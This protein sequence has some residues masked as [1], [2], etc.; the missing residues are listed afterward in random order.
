MTALSARE[1]LINLAKNEYDITY[2]L[3]FKL[4]DDTPHSI[5]VVGNQKV[6]VY[7][8]IPAGEVILRTIAVRANEQVNE[9]QSTF[10]FEKAAE[11]FDEFPDAFENFEAAYASLSSIPASAMSN[12]KLVLRYASIQ[13]EAQAHVSSLLAKMRLTSDLVFCYFLT[14]HTDKNWEL[15][16]LY[17][18]GQETK[19]AL[20]E[21]MR[22]QIGLKADDSEDVDSDSNDESPDSEGK[23]A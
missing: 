23:Q 15:E 8:E 10:M 20:S 21:F 2:G 14:L 13:R 22:E 17:G 16:D 11:I 12:P 7:E 9:R 18:L 4:P 19:E 3:N 6:K 5:K 1:Q